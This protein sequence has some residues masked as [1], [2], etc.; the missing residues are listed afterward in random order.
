MIDHPLLIEQ[1]A[2]AGVKTECTQLDAKSWL[3]FL[4]SINQYYHQIDENRTLME[5]TLKLSSEEVYSSLKFSILGKM[6]AGIAHEIN[7]PLATVKLAA[8]L[9]KENLVE[10]IPDTEFILE[11]IELV[12]RTLGRINTLIKNLRN[13][14]RDGSED[15][16]RRESI[17]EIL[18]DALS[19]CKERFK[20]N[21]IEFRL[22]FPENQDFFIFCRALQISQ[23]LLNLL[24]NSADSVETLEEKWIELRVARV[25]IDGQ[26]KIELSVLDSGKHM[27][28]PFFTP[29]EISKGSG[30]GL[31]ISSGYIKN[32]GGELIYDS[33]SKN[34][35]FIIKLPEIS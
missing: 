6:A 10:S 34:N 16:C 23:V 18:N 20:K 26:N 11:K 3:V 17:R 19:L 15:L 9:V 8:D 13:F 29:K 27:F 24:A 33:L 30:M 25:K 5:Y 35:C 31:S 21:H 7:T 12:D 2:N 28:N 14:A 1:M 4:E 22:V 32:H